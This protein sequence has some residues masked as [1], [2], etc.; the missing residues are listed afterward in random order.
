MASG[1]SGRISI[2]T[3]P[4]CAFVRSV[5]LVARKHDVLV[6][7]VRVNASADSWLR[8]VDNRE[9]IFEGILPAGAT[10]DWS[11]PGPFH[12]KREISTRSPFTGM[13]KWSI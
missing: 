7:H 10:K 1:G 12:I 3:C 6:Q 2:W 4:G 13:I 11:G 8:V 9:L 5:R